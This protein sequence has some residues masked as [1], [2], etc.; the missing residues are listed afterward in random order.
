[1]YDIY[2]YYYKNVL[3]VILLYSEI[4]L[5]KVKSIAVEHARTDMHTSENSD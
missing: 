5:S 2:N 3:Q 1:M 4:N